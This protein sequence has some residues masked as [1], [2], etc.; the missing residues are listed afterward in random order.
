[1]RTAFCFLEDDS[2]ALAACSRHDSFPRSASEARHGPEY[3]VSNIIRDSRHQSSTAEAF[4]RLYWQMSTPP[5]SAG[6]ELELRS[7][8]AAAPVAPASSRKAERLELHL[9]W[10]FWIFLRGAVCAEVDGERPAEEPVG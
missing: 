8:T 2:Q 1:M 4:E 6:E 7:A 5:A 3:A 9:Q 10:K